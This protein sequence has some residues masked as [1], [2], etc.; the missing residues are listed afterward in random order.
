MSSVIFNI[1]VDAIVREWY[2]LV[3]IETVSCIG[4]QTTFYADNGGPS[5][6]N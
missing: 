5:G 6:G 4:H 3:N 1:V 2:T